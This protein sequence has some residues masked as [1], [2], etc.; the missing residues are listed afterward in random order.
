MSEADKRDLAR[1]ALLFI[2]GCVSYQLIG[3]LGERDN[4]VSG[5]NFIIGKA[6]YKCIK[7]NELKE[8]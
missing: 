1:I 2:I 8:D 3:L 7:T 6:A 4:V 5:K